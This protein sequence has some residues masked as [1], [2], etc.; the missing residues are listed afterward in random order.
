M[1]KQLLPALICFLAFANPNFAQVPVTPISGQDTVSRPII[2]AVPFL[3]IAPDARSAGMGDAGV[4]T[5][6][7]A[8]SVHW[9]P[10][11]L[12]FIEQ[13]SGV[14]ISVTPWL[15]NLVGDMYLY[16]LSGYTKIS[17]NEAIAVSMRYFDLGSMDF[18][19]INRNLITTVNPREYAFDATYSRKLSNKFGMGVTAR[20]IRSNL[21]GN[22]SSGPG[23]N[24]IRP[25]NSIAADVSAFYVNNDLLLGN[26]KSKL[27]F[28]ANM[29]NIG[30]KITY[31]DRSQRDFIPTNLRLGTALTTEF[32]AY[33]KLTFAFD[34]NK[35]MVPTPPALNPDGTINAGRDPSDIG[36]VGGMFRSFGDAP[37]G[38]GEELREL[39]LST[40]VEYW[41][42]DL[43]AIRGG[44]FHENARK[45][46]RQY[47]TLGLGLRYQVFGIDFAYLISR[48]QNN[49]LQD[50]VRFTLLFNLRG[51][52]DDTKY[53]STSN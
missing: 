10:A 12:A 33:N 3:T 21:T 45:G 26:Y 19:D 27:A 17:Q 28:G 40:G 49:P 47:F 29:S 51:K 38:L 22:F 20:Y 25:A 8:N 1:L 43:V 23:S 46:N 13:K 5:T 6:P 48:V 18:T 16:Y 11:K 30:P 53:E 2:T 15:Q 50:T 9:N 39:I 32:D 31:T 7:D 37:D 4:A 41:Y 35:L 52:S 42:N 44:Y 14:G 34:L 24:D 36:W